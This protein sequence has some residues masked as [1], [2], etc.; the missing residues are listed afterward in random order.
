MSHQ[1]LEDEVRRQQARQQVKYLD[2]RASLYKYSSSDT[3]L[4]N[5]REQ[6]HLS[7][8]IKFLVLSYVI[9]QE[10]IDK[11][12][13]KL[14]YADFNFVMYK[15]LEPP[16]LEDGLLVRKLFG[17]HAICPAKLVESK[18]GWCAFRTDML[19]HPLY[20]GSF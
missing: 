2:R 3:I 17:H 14:S 10:R 13:V 16:K 9:L 4:L 20:R 18:G 19:F 11:M 12:R 7:L 15:M 8:T 5:F 1:T 6:D